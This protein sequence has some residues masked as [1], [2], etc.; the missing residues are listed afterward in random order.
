MKKIIYLASIVLSVILVSCSMN[1][2]NDGRFD[3]ADPT[4][5]WVQFKSGSDV[6]VLYHP[7]TK[8]ITLPVELKAPKNLGGITISYAV[9]DVV[10]N[11]S[12]VI[13][14][15]SGDIEIFENS[16]GEVILDG[17]I[18][19]NIN[20]T[21]AAIPSNIVFDVTL[22]ATSESNVSVGLSDNSK[23]VTVTVHLINTF[24]ATA[25]I[26][27]VPVHPNAGIEGP[28]FVQ[29]IVPVA[30]V[31]N[32][33]TVASAWGT[34]FVPFLTGNPTAI[35][36]YPAIITIAS[37]PI[38]TGANAGKYSVTVAGNDPAFPARYTGGN[39]LYDPATGI[40]T[41]NLSQGVFGPAPNGNRFT[42]DV[43]YTPQD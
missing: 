3:D 34:Q 19:V 33:F 8:T 10:G 18:V 2:E 36:D 30:G 25:V 31:A 37:T 29:T 12:A 43:V 23:P 6:Y 27:N 20:T 21:E 16:T 14:T 42:V 32:Q 38:T 41:L 1:D 40:F 13:P 4:S 5:G 26:S 24:D 11:S 28:D 15:R 7:L 35:R 17:E 39:G 9:S 22:T